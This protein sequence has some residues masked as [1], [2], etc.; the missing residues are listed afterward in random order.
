MVVTTIA[1]LDKKRSLVTLEDGFSFVLYKGELRLYKVFEGRE[2]DTKSYA[3]IIDS[4]LPKRA[5]L[6]AMNLLKVRPYTYKGLRDKLVEGHY[7]ESI[8]DIAMEYV[9][10]YGYVDDEEYVR[11]YIT[12]YMDRKNRVRLKQELVLKGAPKDI[13]ERVM[14]EEFSDTS[15][16]LER[17][18]IET[19]LRKKHFDPDTFSYEDRMKLMASLARKG[20][21]TDLVKKVI[22]NFE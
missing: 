7:P 22:G 19:F 2:I 8:I 1:E 21:S 10:S 3:E 11:Q 16:D 14:D 17:I 18:Q 20:Y 6:R 15:A 13:I 12:T 5:K 9:C 4:V